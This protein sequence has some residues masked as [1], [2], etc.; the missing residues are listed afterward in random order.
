[1]GD[2]QINT[3]NDLLNSIPSVVYGYAGSLEAYLRGLWKVTQ[4]CRHQ[5][6]SPAL[7]EQVLYEAVM[8]EPAPFD[9]DWLKYERPP[10]DPDYQEK[11]DN[12]FTYFKHTILFQIADLRRMQEAGMLNLS[13]IILFGG[14]DSP[15]GNRW[16]NFDV[17]D[18][19]T[20]AERGY[21]SHCERFG[22]PDEWSQTLPPIGH[23]I[24]STECNWRDLAEIL[25]FG[26]IYE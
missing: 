8:A 6:T 25:E 16:Y 24:N 23:P 3:L 26:R 13:P 10:F 12:G 21:R 20:C 18:Y 2:N 17:F 11:H 4:K 1:M 15:S 9:K 5:T 7:I 22:V 14:V 19:F